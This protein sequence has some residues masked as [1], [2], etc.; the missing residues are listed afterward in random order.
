PILALL[1]VGRDTE[2]ARSAAK[3]L[4]SGSTARAFRTLLRYL[5]KPSGEHRRIDVNQWAASGSAWEGLLAALTVHLHLQEPWARASWAREVARRAIAW[6]NAG[7]EWIARQALFLANA[8]SP[9]YCERE[10][11]SALP[12]TNELQL[13]TLL[14]PKSDWQKALTA[15]D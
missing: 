10:L 9:E 13:W 4:L 15:L 7:Y 3:Q 12:A 1:L 2:S 11:G 6:R 14:T 8:L 5:E